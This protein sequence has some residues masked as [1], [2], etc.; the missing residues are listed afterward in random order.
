MTK[1]DV[2]YMW[3]WN[4]GD[5]NFVSFPGGSSTSG[6]SACGAKETDTTANQRERA[7]AKGVYK[8]QLT[9]LIIIYH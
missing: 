7:S 6:C 8:S 9:P 2:V 5:C 1:E 3:F 4:F